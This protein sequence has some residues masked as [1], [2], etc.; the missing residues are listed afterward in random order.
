MG[1]RP[2]LIA[3]E[4]IDGAGKSTALERVAA[5]LRER[6]LAV[7]R[8]RVGKRHRS[9]PARAIRD[10]SR[11]VA[12]L[13]LCPR[14]ELA[15]YCARE[16]QVLA[17]SVGP[18]LA[19][20]ELVLLDRSLL[21]P[22]VLGCWGRGL[23]LADCEAMARA[24]RGDHPVPELTLVFDVDPRT[25]R[26]RKQIGKIRSHG[27]REGGRKGLAGSAFKARIR[28][29]Y[30]ALAEGDPSMRLLVNERDDPEQVTARVLAILDG[31][32]A[33]PKLDAIPWWRTS[34]EPGREL[35]AI[36][37]AIPEPLAIYLSRGLR[38]ARARRERASSSD[39]SL[40][41]WSLDRED[42]LREPLAT[43]EPGDPIHALAGLRRV[44]LGP[45]DLRLRCALRSPGAVARSL[46]GVAG[47][48][49][50]ELRRALVAAIPAQHSPTTRQAI[51]GGLLASV[52]GREDRFAFELRELLWSEVDS[53]DRAASLRG[54][55]GP[56]AER[57]RGELFDLDP[58][59]A[60]DSLRGVDPALAD[61]RLEHYAAT[62]PKPVLRA[63]LGRADPRA[64]AL[65]ERLIATGSEVVE[66]VAGLADDPSH[67][68]REQAIDE[69]PLG[70]VASLV[71]VELDQ[72]RAARLLARLHELAR[73][74]LELHC[75][76][77]RLRSE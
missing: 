18:A 56:E 3:F 46:L 55:S 4:G 27:F 51:A 54:C 73:D 24:A 44:P 63:L 14:A 33:R 28:A 31:A 64:H 70:V 50:D 69:W 19:R 58:A 16:A 65:R 13:D 8:P 9:R 7:H 1:P 39:P 47:Q 72:P 2:R 42:P 49:A 10:L 75:A 40:V 26:Q 48:S 30:L 43:E 68:L 11:D 45:D 57:L 74:D 12:N 32:P 38:G 37:D 67:A 52:A 23:P 29:G 62:A 5:A 61:P 59:R 60:L 22:V 25:A 36:L 6:G 35:D 15:L 77:L 34:V 76:L 66:S 17:E 21:T 71:G 41:A 53:F 20:G